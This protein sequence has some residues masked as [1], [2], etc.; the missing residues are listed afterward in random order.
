MGPSATLTPSKII[1]S[2]HLCMERQTARSLSPLNICAVS[3]VAQRRS[4]MATPSISSTGIGCVTAYS[5]THPQT[6]RHGSS[7][8][9]WPCS[10]IATRTCSQKCWQ[11]FLHKTKAFCTFSE[12]PTMPAQSLSLN[13][14]NSRP[15]TY[16]T[17]WAH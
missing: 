3:K 8:T 17:S 15:Q 11:P 1:S 16:I 4:H 5:N 2:F 13:I 6:R 10:R 12:T 7:T 9:S 14:G